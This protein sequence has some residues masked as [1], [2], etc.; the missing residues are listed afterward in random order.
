MR[1]PA[2]NWRLG[3]CWFIATFDMLVIL[4]ASGLAGSFFFFALLQG[5]ADGRLERGWSTWSRC[6]ATSALLLSI[7]ATMVAGYFGADVSLW[8]SAALWPVISLP[9]QGGYWVVV[10]S[11]PKQTE[12][13]SQ[14]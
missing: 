2:V 11:C 7:S 13:R 8:L 6:V 5:V 3:G 10:N 14:G 12:K 9:L 1:K 4:I